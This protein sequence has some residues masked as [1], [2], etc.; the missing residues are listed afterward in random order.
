MITYDFSRKVAVVTGA[1]G[2]MG[3]AISNLILNAGG[4]VVMIDLKPEPEEIAGSPDR[5]VYARG[6]L[7]EP[8]FVSE[9]IDQGAA[10]FGRIDYLANVAGVLRFGDDASL[11]DMDM[12][13]WDQVFDTNLKSMVHTARAAVPHMR[14]A[15]GGAMVHFSSTQCLRG[16]PLPQDA[17]STAK[18]GV[19]ALSRSLAMQLAGD[20]IRSN[21][22]YPGLTETPL[23]ARWDTPD[24]I[25][26]AGSWVPMG[27]IGTPEE[28]AH[29]AVYLLSDGASY[30]TGIDLVVDGG[31]LLK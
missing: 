28:L 17:Y 5:R 14:A 31:L 19:G 27:R 7:T 13:I 21:A 4:R 22:I 30:I 10:R 20:G 1:G 24:K 29:A 12:A 25:A 15:G 8:G 16:D 9:T 18:A 3:L 23:Q 2:G 6:D 11:L 26:E